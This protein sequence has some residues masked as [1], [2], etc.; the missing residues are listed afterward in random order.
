[1]RVVAGAI[2]REGRVL[3]SR[4]APERRQGGLWELAG[5]RVEPGESD[6]EALV[7][8]LR[9]ELSVEVEVG[10][11]LGE[12]S[13][14]YAHGEV[15]LVGYLARWRAGEPALRDHDAHRWL[16]AHELL[17]LAWA[18]A[19]LPLLGPLAERLRAGWGSGS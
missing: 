17:A 3:A 5:G 7:R 4:R 13:H 11:C 12:S 18:P 1:M 9:E 16:A 19:D 10:P 15:V 14:T 6:A 2:V 8:E